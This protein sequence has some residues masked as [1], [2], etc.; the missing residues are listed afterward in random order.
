MPRTLTCKHC[1]WQQPYRPAG[2]NFIL[3]CPICRAVLHL[4]CEYGY[5]PVTPCRIYYRG[6]A[7]GIVTA[8]GQRGYW[9]ESPLL[10]AP[11]RL[12]GKSLAALEQAAELAGAL[13]AEAGG[14]CPEEQ[15]RA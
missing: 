10:D 12:E 3:L 1:G 4:E 2:A 5:G 7:M 13:A 8:D 15:D 11:R 9:L 6:Q 14:K